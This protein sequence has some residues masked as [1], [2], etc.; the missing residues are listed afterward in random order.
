MR[1]RRRATRP[2]WPLRA[3]FAVAFPAILVGILGSVPSFRQP[4]PSLGGERVIDVYVPI[5][6]AMVLAMLALTTTPQVLGTYR[7]KGTLRRLSA[8][9]VSPAAL[10]GAQLAMSLLVAT[11]AMTLVAGVGR[12]AFGVALPRQLLG[13][14]VVLALGAAA[15]YAVGLVLAA[16]VSTG[17]AAGAIGT[18]LLFPV[19]FFGGLWIPREEMP[20]LP[21]RVSDFTPLGA[22]VQALHDTSAG[23]WPQ[24]QQVAVMAAYVVVFGLLAARWFRWE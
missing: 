16:V 15:L 18:V 5:A 20:E 14:V 13:F 23:S 24:P 11:V 6:I 10:L 22:G 21:R 17:R 3:F 1:E 7:E 2:P 8:T 12:V 9:P 19:L 4:D